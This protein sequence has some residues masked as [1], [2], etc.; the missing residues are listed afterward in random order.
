MASSLREK[1]QIRISEI[2]I[3]PVWIRKQISKAAIP[4]V[5]VIWLAPIASCYVNVNEDFQVDM[6]ISLWALIFKAFALVKNADITDGQ[7]ITN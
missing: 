3:W 6:P 5:G 1:E 7:M 4:P 2:R